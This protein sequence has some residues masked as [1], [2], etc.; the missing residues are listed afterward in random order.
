MARHLKRYIW[1]QNKTRRILLHAYGLGNLLCGDGSVL[2][3]RDRTQFGFRDLNTLG[4]FVFFFVNAS[5]IAIRVPNG[6]IGMHMG[7]YGGVTD[8]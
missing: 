2:S 5:E 8:A 7:A 6:S 3:F 1:S 4:T